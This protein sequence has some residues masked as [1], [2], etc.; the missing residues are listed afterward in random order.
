MYKQSSGYYIYNNNVKF[1]FFDYIDNTKYEV[2]DVGTASSNSNRHGR[3]IQLPF[4]VS[5]VLTIQ[6]SRIDW[7]DM[8]DLCCMYSP[9]KIE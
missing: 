6:V 4:N 2:T 9:I 8:A 5:N 1:I 7:S 3:S